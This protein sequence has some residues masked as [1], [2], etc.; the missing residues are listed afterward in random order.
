[1]QTRFALVHDTLL[2]TKAA[3]DAVLKKNE[4]LF[5]KNF[6][7]GE[8]FNRDYSGIFCWPSGDRSNPNRPFLTFEHGRT[9]LKAMKGVG[10]LFI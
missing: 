4:S 5:R 7:H 8:L 1:L 10:I 3:L 6:R 9:I 2:V